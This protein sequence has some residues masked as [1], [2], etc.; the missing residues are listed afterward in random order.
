[1]TY[2][3]RPSLR[4]A[5]AA[6]ASDDHRRGDSVAGAGD[7]RHDRHLQRL[8]HGAAAAAPLRR[9]GSARRS[10][11]ELGPLAARG[12]VPRGFRGLP[13]R[14][15][16]LRGPGRHPQRVDEPDR[17]RRPRTG[18]RQLGLRQFPHAPRRPGDRR[19][20]VRAGRRR[21]GAVGSRDARRGPVETALRRTCRHRRRHGHARGQADG[22]GRRAAVVVPVRGAG[23]RLAPGRRGIPRS[24]RC[25]AISPPTAT[26]TSFR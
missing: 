25:P 22:S 26:C 10:V 15:P 14:E 20:H 18:P 24:G 13:P 19:P 3:F 17:R 8:R 16:Q 1:M 21:A 2:D 6:Q 11:G 7:R 12:V 23:R 5:H 4:R 9:S